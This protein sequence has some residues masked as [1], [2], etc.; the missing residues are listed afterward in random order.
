MNDSK[1]KVLLYFDDS[2]QAFYAAVQTATLL[3]NMPDMHLTVVQAQEGIE[4]FKVTEYSWIDTKDLV[5]WALVRSKAKG[6]EYYWPIRSNSDWMKQEK[7]IKILS[8]VNELFTERAE[9]VSHVVIYCDSS[10][11][12]TLEALY[13]YAARNSYNLIVIGT[14]GLTTLKV[15]ILGCLVNKSPIPM[16]LVKKLP[17]SFIKQ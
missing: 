17:Q 16:M 14:R 10:V 3:K 4:D 11:S 5:N 2:M 7:Y 15:L 6:A 8:E 13:D 1:Y 9:N 12:N